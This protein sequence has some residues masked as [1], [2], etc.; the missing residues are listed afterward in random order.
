VVNDGFG[1][2]DEDAVVRELVFEPVWQFDLRNLAAFLPAE[3]SFGLSLLGLVA[4]F[5][6]RIFGYEDEIG[7][8]FF[9]FDL[10]GRAEIERPERGGRRVASKVAPASSLFVHRQDACTTLTGQAVLRGFGEICC[11]NSCGASK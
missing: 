2:D 11:P 9:E 4:V 5:D 6:D 10:I 1:A 7:F 8:A 3:G